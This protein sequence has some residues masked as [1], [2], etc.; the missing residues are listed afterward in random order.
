MNCAIAASFICLSMWI[1]CACEL[2]KMR[3]QFVK[4]THLNR[5]NQCYMQTCPVWSAFSLD[6]IQDV[7][8]TFSF[9]SVATQFHIQFSDVFPCKKYSLLRKRVCK[10]PLCCENPKEHFLQRHNFCAHKICQQDMLMFHNEYSILF[11][12]WWVRICTRDYWTVWYSLPILEKSHFY[13][14]KI[15]RKLN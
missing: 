3:H 13:C 15:S 11:F 8:Q 10:F 6:L 12:L 14:A 1:M 4:K 2:A 5:W 9:C 7:N